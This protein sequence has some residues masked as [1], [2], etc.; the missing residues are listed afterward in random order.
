MQVF[1][2]DEFAKWLRNLRDREARV[3]ILLRIDRMELDNS[4]V[5]RSVGAGV[6]EMKVDYGPGYRIYYV[7]RGEHV[8]VLLCGGDKSTQKED[9]RRAKVLAKLWQEGN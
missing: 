9:I 1:R 3:R 2:T 8:V 6:F 5:T 4:G 7:Q